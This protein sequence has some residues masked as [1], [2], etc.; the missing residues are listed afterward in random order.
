MRET[1]E[2][3]IQQ[4]AAP[5][6]SIVRICDRDIFLDASGLY[7]TPIIFPLPPSR[8]PMQSVTITLRERGG[9]LRALDT[10]QA[11]ARLF[12]LSYTLRQSARSMT[13]LDLIMMAVGFI[14]FALSLAYV[15]A[16]D[17]L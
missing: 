9:F 3:V 4:R 5:I 2:T 16:C 15:Y 13:M 8:I 11:R 1:P 12:C 14:L 7:G 6:P 17:Q 10:D